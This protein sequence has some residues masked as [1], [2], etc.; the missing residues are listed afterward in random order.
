MSKPTTTVKRK[1]I[2]LR[3]AQVN[4]IWIF[5][6]V[7][8]FL[9]RIYWFLAGVDLTIEKDFKYLGLLFPIFTFFYCWN[10]IANVYK[11][12]NP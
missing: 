4:S 3:F 7:M 11:S 9:T 5:G 1:K 6:G 10:L 12:I 2:K 8:L